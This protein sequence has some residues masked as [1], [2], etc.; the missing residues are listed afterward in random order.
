M[1]ID[2]TKLEKVRDL[3]DGS[4]QAR[5]PACAEGGGDRKGEHLRIYPDGR[6][7]CCVFAGDREHRKRIFALA[8]QRSR[9]GITVKVAIPKSSGETRA[10]LLGRLG[11][12]FET[13]AK[14]AM[15]DQDKVG[16][17]GTTQYSRACE[18]EK[19]VEGSVEGEEAYR[20]LIEFRKCVPSVP[21][22]ERLPYLTEGGILVI[23]FDS[24]ERFHWWK[25][26]QSVATT[27]IEV[28]KE[29]HAA[30]V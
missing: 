25:G 1:S 23:P 21:T 17:F 27:L 11:R 3:P 14:P 28:R 20:E 15:D 2:L 9:R 8:G 16:T 5:C 24:P 13:P 30:T 18:K 26:G 6:F 19:S 22:A 4:T 7:G 12:V 10:G 29:N